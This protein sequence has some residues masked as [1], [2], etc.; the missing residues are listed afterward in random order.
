VD[1]GKDEFM[2]LESAV[3]LK[4]GD[5]LTLLVD[6]NLAHL[7]DDQKPLVLTPTSN[8][9]NMATENLEESIPNGSTITFCESS[10]ENEDFWNK[11]V[12]EYRLKLY[13]EQA[14]PA[15]KFTTDSDGQTSLQPG[16]GIETLCQHNIREAQKKARTF[17]HLHNLLPTHD[18]IVRPRSVRSPMYFVRPNLEMTLWEWLVNLFKGK[19][20]GVCYEM[21]NNIFVWN[22]RV[23]K[24]CFTCDTCVKKFMFNNNSLARVCPVCGCPPSDLPVETPRR[25]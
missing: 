6:T 15:I 12:K 21:S 3:D 9:E 14:Y 25:N 7:V 18:V 20:C 10:S 17:I 2:A 4:L 8:L 11:K 13:R 24:E 19:E 22:G 1:L 23:C 5:I 16:I